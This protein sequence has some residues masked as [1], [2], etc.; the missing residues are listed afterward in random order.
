M[1]HHP[2][3]YTCR[4]SRYHGFRSQG[5]FAIFWGAREVDAVFEEGYGI[6]IGNR[7]YVCLYYIY[8]DIYIIYIIYIYMCVL[9]LFD[10]LVIYNE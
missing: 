6:W 4:P 1:L 9:Y 8:V 2:Y 10:F 5:S 3:F 7:R